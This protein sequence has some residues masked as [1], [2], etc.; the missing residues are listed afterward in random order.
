MNTY[1]VSMT[2]NPITGDQAP[3]VSVTAQEFVVGEDFVMFLD[4]ARQVVFAA[5]LTREPII[6]RTVSG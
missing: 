1:S 6:T 3:A 5:P 2:L 4:D